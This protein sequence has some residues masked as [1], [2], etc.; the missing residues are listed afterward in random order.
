MSPKLPGSS[1][2]EHTVVFL[3]QYFPCFSRDVEAHALIIK[4]APNA[5]PSAS[6]CFVVGF[7]SQSLVRGAA[8]CFPT[9][10]TGF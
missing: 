7:P 9:V 3:G 5:E 2:S 4:A 6:L 8:G 10:L 1:S